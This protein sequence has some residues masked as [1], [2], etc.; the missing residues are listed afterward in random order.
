MTQA[1]PPGVGRTA[2]GVG[3]VVLAAGGGTRFEGA[4]HKLVAPFR[5]RP[6][7]AWSIEAALAA[8]LGTVVVVS[9]AVRLD[10]LVGEI[11]GGTVAVV[12]NDRW[13]AGQASSLR[14][15]I[16]W[17]AARGLEAAVVGAGDQPL[18]GAAAW[19]AVAAATHAPVVTATFGGRRRPP[20]RLDRS[21]WPLLASEGDEGARQLMRRHPH[22]V[23]EVAC[24]GDPTDVDTLDDLLRLEAEAVRVGGAGRDATGDE[25]DSTPLEEGPWS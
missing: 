7:V 24:E 5:G 13:R 3:A 4:A 10:E 6:L 22:L 9:G 17:C 16:E 15:G 2:A 19:R 18:V 8:G 21:V 11:A 25:H 20:V 23:G 14:V 1:S 12:A